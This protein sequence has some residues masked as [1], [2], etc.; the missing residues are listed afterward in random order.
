MAPVD[1]LSGGQ[2]IAARQWRIAW[3]GVPSRGESALVVSP[4]R[5]KLLSRRSTGRA[6][7]DCWRF[8]VELVVAEVPSG[9][10]DPAGGR[11]GA[12]SAGLGCPAGVN[13]PRPEPPA[14]SRAAASERGRLRRPQPPRRAIA[15]DD[16][17]GGA[18]PGGWYAAAMH[19][20]GPF[21]LVEP[22][23]A[24]ASGQVF[25]A[26]HL[27]SGVPVAVKVDR[28]PSGREE[29]E[30]FRHEMRVLAGLDHPNVALILDEGRVTEAE[31][32]TNALVAEAYWLA[33]ELAAG[34]VPTRLP[35]WDEVEHVVR[36][37][38]EGLAHAHA[39]GVVHR[40]IK[41]SNLLVT[42]HESTL[43][44]E[45]P[46]LL[47]ARVVVAD[48]GIST[49][50]ALAVQGESAGTPSYMA[51]ELIEG[52]AEQGPWTDLYAVGVLLWRLTTGRPPFRGREI[53]EILKGH[54]YDPLPPYL[55]RMAVPPGL[56]AL[57]RDL[58]AKRPALRPASAAEVL[59]RLS[60]LGDPGVAPRVGPIE[61]PEEH[62]GETRT[63]LRLPPSLVS[64]LDYAARPAVRI[65]PT[66]RRRAPPRRGFCLAGAGL[67]LLPWRVPPF[68]GRDA[69]RD[70]LWGA[71][72]A[73][74]SAGEARLILLEG[75]SGV[76]RSRLAAWVVEASHEAGLGAALNT[77]ARRGADAS[78]L[79]ALEQQLA[80]SLGGAASPRDGSSVAERRQAALSELGTLAET[81]PI[82]WVIDDAHAD[83]AVLDLVDQ[84]LAVQGL[85]PSPVLVVATIR[86]DERADDPA[87][88]GLL[89]ELQS[90]PRSTTLPVAPLADR[91]IQE[92][93]QSLLGLDAGLSRRI[94]E[95]SAGNPLF[96]RTLVEE[97]AAQGGLLPTPDGFRL[98]PGREVR[99]PE[100]LGAAWQQ[101]VS[102]AFDG[103]P[104][105]ELEAL[106]VA[107]LFGDR[108][109]V[110]AWAGACA[111]LHLPYVE[112][113]RRLEASGL[114]VVGV[115]EKDW[116]FAHGAARAAA[117]RHL[118]PGA[119]RAAADA[120]LRLDGDRRLIAE[121]LVEAGAHVQALPHVEA[122]IVE[123]FDRGD[124]RC[125]DLL[126]L[127]ERVLHEV[128]DPDA[129][130][131][132][133]LYRSDYAVLQ[134]RLEEALVHA[135]RGVQQSK[136]P[137]PQGA[138]EPLIRGQAEL[139]LSRALIRAWE[140]DRAVRSARRAIQGFEAVGSE[141]HVG[142]ART[143]LGVA[144]L[145]RGRADEALT[146]LLEAAALCE[147]HDPEYLPPML[148]LVNAYAAS[149]DVDAQ[150][151][152][153]QRAEAVASAT[154]Q[155]RA[156]ATCVNKLGEVARA[157]GQRAE[158]RE[159][160]EESVRR[161][162]AVEDAGFLYPL[163]NLAML[164]VD[165]RAHVDAMARAERLRHELKRKPN[166]FIAAAADGIELVAL[167]GVGGIAGVP[168][169]LQR[170]AAF[171]NGS[172]A[173]DA[174][175][176]QLLSMGAQL[177]EQ[178]GHAALAHRCE[179][180]A[181]TQ[182]TR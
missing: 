113:L 92:M 115:G 149:G 8:V 61:G 65:G 172:R 74:R 22:I 180:L 64:H 136:R 58:L 63:T 71:W 176:E 102:T 88:D 53:L 135:E 160:F 129:S 50:G 126:D 19:R 52:R 178:G 96:A 49:T 141:R 75:P 73:V 18:G 134:G 85:T 112:A 80:R 120:L 181:R 117:A 114:A 155:K 56:E 90:D 93:V 62:L 77:P 132:L 95:L 7:G 13:L 152:W 158:A 87:V 111:A 128:D 164:D 145:N 124:V 159:R 84:L 146:E 182:R 168:R 97:A 76:G 169:V 143:V 116:R 34:T 23:G 48:F 38:L 27:G 142:Y 165:A 140:L 106:A 99:L 60:E 4:A 127:L 122:A 125:A 35:G 166:P 72:V 66:P 31:A 131:R 11:G 104:H 29:A 109:P 1:D 81:A 24:G 151:T 179:A 33:M 26:R 103:R 36:S 110:D 154:N 98:A 171:V 82:L 57:C 41:P 86:S 78:C 2:R 144:L 9:M 45:A 123:E 51:P 163:L 32:R 130:C 54:L 67:G 6:P 100:D 69:E 175:L 153:A 68:V 79:T 162:R 177:L 21:E 14:P 139:A 156:I 15:D 44:T 5:S 40:D 91:H 70:A 121:C 10:F 150:E 101:R 161:Y 147:R 59:R 107:T 118:P 174:R 42:A 47:D 12:D 94:E 25:R 43:R 83:P 17:E 3:V 16:E 138:P 148:H 133:H 173:A 28:S 137:R 108:V 119:H 55:P 20:L 46:S 39:R 167:A 105:A 30:A 89:R 157:R 37:T 170:M